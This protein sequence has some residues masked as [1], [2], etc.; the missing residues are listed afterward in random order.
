[1]MTGDW[2]IEGDALTKKQ[3]YFSADTILLFYTL[4]CPLESQDITGV[5]HAYT[6]GRPPLP[7]KGP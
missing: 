2:G 3:A 4:L 1:M 7:G 6:A 5:R